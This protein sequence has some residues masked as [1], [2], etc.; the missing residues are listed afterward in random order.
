L[1]PATYF[2]TCADKEEATKITNALLNARICA[3]VKQ[4]QVQ[5]T[6]HWDGEIQQSEEILLLI[7]SSEEKF[8]DIEK[9][10]SE[11][12]SYDEYVLTAIPIVKTTPG[13]IKWL[14][15]TIS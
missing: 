12:H 8:D 9:I 2:L 7:E 1:K 14:E 15:E 4:T 10:V 6:F 11:L 13:V 3:C 5:S